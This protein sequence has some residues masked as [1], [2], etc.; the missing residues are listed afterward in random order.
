MEAGARGMLKITLLLQQFRVHENRAHTHTLCASISGGSMPPTR[1][2][3]SRL[4]THAHSFEWNQAE[5]SVGLVISM[6]RIPM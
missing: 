2:L 1:T 6:R 5:G 4:F 3:S